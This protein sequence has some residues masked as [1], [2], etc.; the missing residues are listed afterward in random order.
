MSRIIYKTSHTNTNTVFLIDCKSASDCQ[1]HRHRVSLPEMKTLVKRKF[2]TAW[3][4]KTGSTY[5]TDR[6]I[7]LNQREQTMIFRLRTGH[8]RLGAHL[9][10]LKVVTT[11]QCHCNTEHQTPK[12]LLQRCPT[13][14]SIRKNIWPQPKTMEE[15]LWGEKDDLQQTT[16]SEVKE[17]KEAE[18]KRRRRITSPPPHRFIW[19][20]L[21]LY[22]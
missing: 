10:K 5:P 16:R 19:P 4:T 1:Q 9:Y 8:C 18:R 17:H 7:H 12:H 13:Y 6:I 3:K 15:K 14:D 22:I 11:P 2:N 21:I 20:F